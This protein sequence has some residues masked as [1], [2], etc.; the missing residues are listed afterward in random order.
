MESRSVLLLLDV[1]L[2]ASNAQCPS[3]QSVAQSCRWRRHG[4]DV[5]HSTQQVTDDLVL[6]LLALLLDLLDL[7]LGLFICFLLGFFVSLGVLQCRRLPSDFQA[8]TIDGKG[9]AVSVLIRTS[10]SNFLYSFSFSDL[11]SSISFL[12]SS[13]ASLTRFVRSGPC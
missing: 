10:A 8:T 12:A 6:A 11:Y 9:T 7:V 13:R 5:E 4:L 1:N 3:Q 2:S